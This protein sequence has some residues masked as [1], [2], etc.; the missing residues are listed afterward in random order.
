LAGE[1]AGFDGH[2]ESAGHGHGV[3]GHG[4]GGVDQDGIGAEFEGFGRVAGRA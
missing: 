3:F 4:D 1:A 2:L